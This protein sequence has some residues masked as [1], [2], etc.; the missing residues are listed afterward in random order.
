VLHDFCMIIP[1]SMLIILAGLVTIPLGAGGRGVILAAV[2]GVEL[3]LSC[4]SLTRFQARESSTPFT[5][6]STGVL[7][8]VMTVLV[9]KV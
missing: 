2:G 5:I 6:G 7:L 9:K 1:F 4:M 3:G 8:G